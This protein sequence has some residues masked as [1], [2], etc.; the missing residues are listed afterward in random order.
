MKQIVVIILKYFTDKDILLC[1]LLQCV[2]DKTLDIC[3]ATFL[4]SFLILGELWKKLWS[5]WKTISESYVKMESLVELLACLLSLLALGWFGR[6]TRISGGG[7]RP[8][9]DCRFSV[10][11][12]EGREGQHNFQLLLNRIK[13]DL[14]IS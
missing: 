8:L 7:S 2:E 3:S 1:I 14:F 13:H 4:S 10:A 11:E 9:I 5:L 12:K 6:W